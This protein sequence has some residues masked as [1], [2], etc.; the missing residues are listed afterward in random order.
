M[1][2]FFL[3]FILCAVLFCPP[4][5]GHAAAQST[6]DATLSHMSLEEKVG[7]LFMVWFEGRENAPLLREA[8]TRRHAGGIILYDI[9]D[10]VGS[11]TEVAR[12]T[13]A[14][15]RMAAESG[16]GVG[17][18]IGI[19][20]EGGPV[21]R[22]K[23]GFTVLPSAA[24]IGA[25]GSPD[26]AAR[27]ASIMAQE[28]R[29][30]G[31]NVTF[32]P[33]A[34]VNSNP[35]NPIIGVR[36]FGGTPSQVTAMARAAMEATMEHGVLPVLKHFPGHGDTGFDSHL[37]LPRVAHPRKRLDAVELAPFR[38]LAQAAPAIMTAHVAVPALE[39]N[40]D[41]P[42]TLSR[43]VL[44]DVLRGQLGF[45]GLV[46]TDSLG[47]GAIANTF[48]AGDAAL[49][50]F[51]AGA[52]LLLFGADKGHSPQEALDAMDTVLRAARRGD[53]SQQRLDASVRR[54]LHVKAQLGALQPRLVDAKAA[55]RRVGTL[56]SRR[57]ADA[58]ALAGTRILRDTQNLLPLPKSGAP[59]VVLPKGVATAD[60][61]LTA[62]PSGTCLIRIPTHPAEQDAATVAA[63]AG[64][65][66]IIVLIGKTGKAPKQVAFLRAL[67]QKAGAQAPVVAAALDM[68]HAVLAET[69]IPCM[70]A[71]WSS[72]PASIRALARTLFHAK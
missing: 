38:E 55:A 67:V 13:N 72:V 14:A 29:A 63:R 17:L 59:V 64:E 71:T 70:V 37:H 49:R 27:A 8:I 6:V 7:Q 5:V 24:A 22:L 58:I 43:R 60:D 26:H 45:A 41:V 12:L 69:D 48:G 30:V 61:I 46:V 39:P 47:M 33:D 51:Q 2:R 54:I 57:A 16:A 9:T 56:G 66:P 40:P 25:S 53:I 3:T 28:M 1:Q 10:N 44:T 34:D 18:L 11:P 62:F 36:S 23:N 65:R 4:T 15:Q 19:D 20:Q 32:A 50:A 52:D 31:I 35:D 42:A 68:P 21:V